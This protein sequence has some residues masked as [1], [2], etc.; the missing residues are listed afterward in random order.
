MGSHRR[1]RL[2]GIDRVE[3]ETSRPKMKSGKCRVDVSEQRAPGT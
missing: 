1:P 3:K 2:A